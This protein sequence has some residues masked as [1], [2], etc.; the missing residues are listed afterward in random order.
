MWHNDR[1]KILLRAHTHTHTHTYIYIY[2]YKRWKKN[3][4]IV[5]NVA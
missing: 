5:A 4:D 3:N 2:I 1:V